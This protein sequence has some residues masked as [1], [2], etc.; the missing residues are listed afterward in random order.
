[1]GAYKNGDAFGTSVYVYFW[2]PEFGQFKSILSPWWYRFKEGLLTIFYGP[3]PTYL[4][5]L[6]AEPWLL[7]PILDVDL[8]TQFSRMNL[9]K[10][11]EVID[12]AEKT[13]YDKQYLWGAEWWYWLLLQGEGEIWEKGKELYK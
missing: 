6:S 9:E 3:K 12:Y 11:N 10:I 2:N 4:I 7:E 8:E 5:E 13:R 1:M